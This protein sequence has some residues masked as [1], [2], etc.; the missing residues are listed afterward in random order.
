MADA[1]P[2]HRIAQEA[3][4]G[5]ALNYPDTIHIRDIANAD[6]LEC[7]AIEYVA[8]KEWTPGADRNFLRDSPRWPADGKVLYLVSERDGGPCI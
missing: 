4:A 6:A 3:K 5:A 2:K 7:I 8:S 1:D